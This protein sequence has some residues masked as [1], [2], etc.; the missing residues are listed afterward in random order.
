MF[1][2]HLRSVSIF[3]HQCEVLIWMGGIWGL[4]AVTGMAGPYPPAP[5]QPGSDAIPL[6]DPSIVEWASGYQEYDLGSPHLATSYPGTGVPY[7]TG[8]NCLGYP[9][10]SSTSNTGIHVTNLGENGS[11]V[12]TFP[13]PIVANGVGDEFA[14]FGNGSETGYCKLG[15]VFVSQNDVN[16][17]EMP[18]YSLTPSPISTYGSN[19]DPTNL[20]GYCG[21]YEAGYGEPF[22]LESVG[23]SEVSY[24]K[25]VDV[26]GSGSVLDSSGNPIYC[27]YPNDDGCNVAGVAVMSTVPEPTTFALLGVFSVIAW[28][29]VEI[30]Q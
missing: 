21:K 10:G 17:V 18:N 3:L 9:A 27:P 13:E 29:S 11:I 22:S 4:T 30:R 23:L 16:W 5:G 25:V 15:Q 6:N 2:H 12:L 24:V 7:A 14:V 19:I 20:E 1:F 8:S 26:Q 28:H